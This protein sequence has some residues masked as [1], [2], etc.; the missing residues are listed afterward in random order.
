MW[1]HVLNRINQ[2]GTNRKKEKCCVTFV[3]HC[4]IFTNRYKNISNRYYPRMKFDTNIDRFVFCCE[5]R[6]VTTQLH[7]K[8]LNFVDFLFLIFS[9][10]DMLN[11]YHH[12]ILFLSSYL[13]IMHMN[14]S[15]LLIAI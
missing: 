3:D 8:Y 13:S 14:Y 9:R 15:T 4:F 5:G 6:T 10:N 2:L 1:M 11:S 12:Y 7:I